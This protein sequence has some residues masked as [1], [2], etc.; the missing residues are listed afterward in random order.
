MP[1][2]ND[3][4]A[5]DEVLQRPIWG[6]FALVKDNLERVLLANVG[7]STQLLPAI[8]ALGFPELPAVIRVL[9]L[10]YSA[11]ALAPATAILYVWMARVSRG[12]ML[13]FEMLKEDVRALT[14]PSLTRMTPLFGLLG[15]SYIAILL[16]GFA[17][18]L[19]LDTLTRFAF[20]ALLMCGQYWGPLFAEYPD[21]SPLFVLRNSFL[22]VWRYPGPTALTGLVVLLVAAFGFFTVMGLFVIVPALIAL[23]QTRR[24]LELLIR[25]RARHKKF[26][27][28]SQ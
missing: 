1:F 18:I 7:W 19:L 3:I 2:L 28:D 4:G 12:E 16:L 14:L 25:Q 23:L 27:V 10:L 9:L 8:A 13:R 20:L 22:L 5:D 11:T 15:L 17:H 6:A 26:E 21:R 24:C